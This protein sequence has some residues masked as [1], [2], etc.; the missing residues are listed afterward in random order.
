MMRFG[1]TLCHGAMSAVNPSRT[2][3]VC[4]DCDRRLTKPT[5]PWQK[6][7]EPVPAKHDGQR[8]VCEKKVEVRVAA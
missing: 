5:H 3:V 6:Y 2:C 8:W 4:I 1:A 7:L